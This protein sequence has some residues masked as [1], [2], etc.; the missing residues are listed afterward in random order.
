MTSPNA[1]IPVSGRI[2]ADLNPALVYIGSLNAQRSRE[3]MLDALDIIADMLSQGQDTAVTYGARWGELRYQHTALIK[4]MLGERYK[5]S[6]VNKMLS[7]LRRVLKEAWRLGYMSHEEYARATD[8]KNLP[9]NA[10]PAG[11]DL[12]PGEIRAMIGVCEDDP[13]PAG[14]RDAA[15]IAVLWVGL[16]RA[17]VASLAVEDY[18]AETGQITVLHGKGNKQRQTYLDA[19]AMAALADWLAVRG[20]TPGA[21]FLRINKS[22]KVHTSGMTNQSIHH[23]VKRRGAAAGV[24]DAACHNFRRTAVGDLL[25]QGVD[26]STVARMMGHSQVQTTAKYDRRPEKMKEQAA[27]TRRLPYRGRG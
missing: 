17:E 16:R 27:N 19:G 22:G 20:D 12:T 4:T 1:I 21:L 8:V 18:N 6:S 24:D 11:R 5:P 26:I 15:I 2:P 23:I 10:L 9:N 25:T 14:A 7:A 13:T 3:T